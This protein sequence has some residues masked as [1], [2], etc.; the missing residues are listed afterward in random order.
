[1][2]QKMKL[3]K[4]WKIFNG[5]PKIVSHLNIHLFLSLSLFLFPHT[6]AI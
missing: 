5:C 1:M 4:I 3:K 6:E 2:L